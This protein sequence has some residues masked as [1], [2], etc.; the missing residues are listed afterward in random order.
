MGRKRDLVV[1]VVK[2]DRE[3]DGESGNPRDACFARRLGWGHAELKVREEKR[4]KHTHTHTHTAHDTHT[5]TR[6]KRNATQHNTTQ[7]HTTQPVGF[8][9]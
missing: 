9:T 7:H 2:H 5:H 4:R 8:G 3:G 1:F 6:A